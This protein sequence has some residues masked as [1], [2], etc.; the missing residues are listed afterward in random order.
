MYGYTVSEMIGFGVDKLI[1]DLREQTRLREL[2]GYM[3]GGKEIGQYEA[4]RN[5]RTGKSITASVSLSPI[6]DIEGRI[7]E[8][9]CIERDISAEKDYEESLVQAKLNAEEASRAKS[10]FLSNMSHELRTPLNSIMGMIGLADDMAVSADQGEYLKIARQSA[11]NLLFLIN[12]I[13]DFSKIEAGKMS[14]NSSLFDP[15]AIVEDCLAEMAVQAH[16]KSLDLLFRADPKVPRSLFGD[17]RCFRQI[18]TNLLSNGIK[19]TESGSVRVDL[20]LDLVSCEPECG[21]TRIIELRVRDT[22]IGIPT[23]RIDLIWHA[24]TQLDGSSTRSYGGTGL[25]LSIVRSFAELMGGSVCVESVLGSGSDFFVSLPFGIGP[26]AGSSLM[27]MHPFPP[28]SSIALALMN[29]DE[30]EILAEQALTW[31]CKVRIL[32]SATELEDLASDSCAEQ[33]LLVLVDDRSPLKQKVPELCKNDAVHNFFGNRLVVAGM[34]GSR[35]DP[36]WRS[37]CPGVEFLSKPVRGDQLCQLARVRLQEGSPPGKNGSGPIVNAIPSA[38]SRSHQ[39]RV[40]KSG[41]Y[42]C[43]DKPSGKVSRIVELFLAEAGLIGSSSCVDLE[44]SATRFRQAIEAQG[45]PSVSRIFFKIIL[46]CRRDDPEGVQK[47]LALLENLVHSGE[48]ISEEL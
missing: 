9:A 26:A 7:V 12:S 15:V 45:A 48:K 5:C 47:E 17:D 16:R 37:L 19:F 32:A 44:N 40:P 30:A 36:V 39:S 41:D 25:G 20:G 13:L 31:P 6:R 43:D 21:D 8:I 23:D 10:D 33:P 34:I 11:G 22:G 1:P 14:L 35:S 3:H 27:D 4:K 46:A 18:V 29:P 28:G 38:V 24:F 2:A 42:A